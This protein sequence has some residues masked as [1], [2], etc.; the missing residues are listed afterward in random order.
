MWNSV[1][2]L[3]VILTHLLEEGLALKQFC[4]DV[5]GCTETV[6]VQWALFTKSVSEFLKWWWSFSC[7]EMRDRLAVLVCRPRL[8][9]WSCQHG[10]K[11]V[12][13]SFVPASVWSLIS[14]LQ[15]FF[16]FTVV[17]IAGWDVFLFCSI[18]WCGIFFL[19][20]YESAFGEQCVG[21]S[22]FVPL[23][24]CCHLRLLVSDCLYNCLAKKLDNEVF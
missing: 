6:W 5:Q 9:L 15:F 13:I 16:W 4:P 10:E 17:V 24:D 14:A 18:A 2:C 11:T 22:F 7:S 12:Q 19:L 1:W 23:R 3:P 8:W 21:L 20:A